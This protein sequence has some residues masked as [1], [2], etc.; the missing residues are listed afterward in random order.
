MRFRNGRSRRRLATLA[1]SHGV[2]KD[3]S[4]DAAGAGAGAAAGAIWTGAAAVRGFGGGFFAAAT[5]GEAEGLGDGDAAGFDAAAGALAAGAAAAR[6]VAGCPGS[7]FMMLTGGVDDALGKS[8]LV[9]LPVGSDGGNCASGLAGAV[10]A[11]T[12]AGAGAG[13]PQDGE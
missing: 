12:G 2:W 4:L 1:A 6:A 3:Q 11:A 5:A 13:S 8:A 10:A 7:G 9:G